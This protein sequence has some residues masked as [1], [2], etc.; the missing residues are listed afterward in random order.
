MLE[1]AA[2]ERDAAL[3]RQEQERQRQR[4]LDRK[5]RTKEQ[6]DGLQTQLKA[7]HQQM[8]R[9]AQDHH[10]EAHMLETKSSSS[11]LE[12]KSYSSFI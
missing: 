9:D 4:E 2:E 1:Q 11:M 3:Q 8:L 12:T 10:Q 7:Q 5:Q 6:M